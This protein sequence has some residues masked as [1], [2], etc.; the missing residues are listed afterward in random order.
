MNYELIIRGGQLLD[1]T[2]ADTYSADIGVVAGRIVAIGPNLEGSAL[3]ELDASG[4]LVT[5]GFIDLHTHYDGQFV[6]DDT[7]DPSFSNG[8]TTVV[9]GNC[10]VGFAP[11]RPEHREPL[12]QLMEGVED[13]PEL[14]LNAGLDWSWETF[15]EYLD[16][17]GQRQYSMDI[18]VQLPHAPL[19]VYVMGERALNHEPATES[20]IARMCELVEEAMAAGAVG[21]SGSR[22]LEHLSSQGAHVPGTFAELSELEALAAAMARSGRGTFQIVPIGTVGQAATIA[23]RQVDAN[24]RRTEH[25][26]LEA[27]AAASGRPVTYIL[28][29][30]NSN[31]LDWKMMLEAAS[32]SN[33][34]GYAMYPQ[35]A[36]RAFGVLLCLEGWHMFQCRPTY[37]A[38]AHL[39]LAERVA[40]MQREDVKQAILTETDVGR[41]DAPSLRVWQQSALFAARAGGQ[42]LMS[43]PLN[44]E[45]DQTQ[46][47]AAIAER[48]GQTAEAVIYDHLLS[49]GG[50]GMIADNMLN[51]ADGN[52][53]PVY[54]ML[55]H[56]CTITGLA[57]GGAHMRMICD[58]SLPAF[59]LNF[60][61]R[62]RKRGPTLPLAF[63]VKR[64]TL[65]NA[66]L[67]G[68]DVDRGSL[69]VGKR[70]D[71][72]IIDFDRLRQELPQ[73]VSDLPGGGSRLL[74][75]ST[76]FRATLVNG[77]ITRE[78]DRDTG[79]RPG[80]LVRGGQ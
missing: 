59:Q 42:F 43:Q 17:L 39:P 61:G 22:I 63:L 49:E 21:V 26:R 16:K 35:I 51:Y 67:Y 66:R 8:V 12:I 10:G 4:H 2:G 45:P 7:L 1:G 34:A 13:I 70:A 14:V 37:M 29:Q 31:P 48:Q 65:D 32:Q 64:Q 75:Q 79:Q 77:V 40:A 78:H 50:R 25:Q 11:A 33:A 15:P 58:A 74:Q 68:L 5:P 24:E 54:E 27:I 69:E 23:G 3:R 72:N 19:R 28:Q 53:D 76:G 46:T 9:A 62:D 57:D 60:W 71:I 80:R 38:L 47:V 56:P 6:W 55:T 41:E 73:M 18:A 44:Y 20:D 30:F 52:L 36:A